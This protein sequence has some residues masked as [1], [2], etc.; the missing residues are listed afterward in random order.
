MRADE[1]PAPPMQRDVSSTE[2]VLTLSSVEPIAV[3]H[4]RSVYQHPHHEN[5][6]IKVMRPDAVEKRWN[7]PG[8]W[9]KRLPRARHYVQY[10]RELKEFIVAR[11]RAPAVDVPIA[12]MIGVVDTD[13]GLGVISEKVV[14]ESGALAPTLAA[15]YAKRGFTPEL[16]AALATFSRDLLAA[17]VIVGDMHAWNIVYGADSRG[18]PR[19]VM[20]DGFGEKHAIPISSMSRA[21]NRYRTKR[22]LKRMVDQVK[23]LVPVES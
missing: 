21:I 1:N 5:A 6:L 17:N 23:K 10:L 20:I 16:D 11:A 14:D 19:L 18:G 7:A 9:A 22:L 8:R 15:V 3:G 13:L 12:R 2:P 4:L